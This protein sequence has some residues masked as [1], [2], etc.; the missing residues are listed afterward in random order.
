[1][2]GGTYF[3]QISGL[4]LVAILIPES[5]T[6]ARIS[7]SVTSPKCVFGCTKAVL[8]ICSYSGLN[9]EGTLDCMR[10]QTHFAD[11]ATLI[12]SSLKPAVKYSDISFSQL[13]I[14]P[15]NTLTPSSN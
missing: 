1:M 12:N 9:G 2:R 10:R 3:L 5:E 6:P 13:S 11:T 15:V 8:S 7:L 4:Q 14:L